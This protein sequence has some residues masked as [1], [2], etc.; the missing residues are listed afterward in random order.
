[1]NRKHIHIQL[2]R[3]FSKVDD[4]PKDDYLS[5]SEIKNHADV[6]TDMRFLDTAKALHDEE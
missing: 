5:L 1:M 3:L 6:F 4:S 2:N